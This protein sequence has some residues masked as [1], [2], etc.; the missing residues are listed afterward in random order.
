MKHLIA[1]KAGNMECYEMPNCCALRI[2]SDIQAIGGTTPYEEKAA[3]KFDTLKPEAGYGGDYV[4][5]T[6]VTISDLDAVWYKRAVAFLKARKYKELG[7]FPGAHPDDW[8]REYR[9]HIFGSKKF[10]L[11]KGNK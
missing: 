5:A 10:K 8:G 3:K 2:V 1:R 9:L 6:V 7:N 4:T 11:P